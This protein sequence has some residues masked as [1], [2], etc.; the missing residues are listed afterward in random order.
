[1]TPFGSVALTRLQD[2]RE[3]RSQPRLGD[4]NGT[5]P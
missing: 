4:T 5:R 2:G 3:R 1:M